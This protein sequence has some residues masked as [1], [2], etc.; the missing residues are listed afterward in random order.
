MRMS[1]LIVVTLTAALVFAPSC[2]KKPGDASY[3]VTNPGSG[4]AN[5]EPLLPLH[6]GSSYLSG[7]MI[8]GFVAGDHPK[9]PMRDGAV[10]DGTA[11]FNGTTAVRYV[12]RHDGA[13]TYLAQNDDGWLELGTTADGPYKHATLLVPKTV[14]VGMTWDSQ[15]DEDHRFKYEV[16]S[17]TE[18]DTPFGTKPVWVIS[19]KGVDTSTLIARSYIEGRGL[20][21]LDFQDKLGGSSLTISQGAVVLSGEFPTPA[22]PHPLAL[23]ELAVSDAMLSELMRKV[24]GD[25]QLSVVQGT[26]GAPLLMAESTWTSQLQDN[27]VS[28]CA[29]V[30]S[31]GLQPGRF[32]AGELGVISDLTTCPTRRFQLEGTNFVDVLNGH[33]DGAM[34]TS[35]GLFWVP[36]EKFGNTVN[37]APNLMSDN[38]VP[39]ALLP[40]SAGG[41]AYVAIHDTGFL[42]HLAVLGNGPELRISDRWAAHSRVY[43]RA[44]TLGPIASTRSMLL[45]TNDGAVRSTF[46]TPSAVGGLALERGFAG[47]WSVGSTPAGTGVFRV[48][49]DGTVDRLVLS[50]AGL[51]LQR[52]GEVQLPA[53]QHLIGVFEVSLEGAPAVIAVTRGLSPESHP[54]GARPYFDLHVF[55]ITTALAAT[56]LQ[57][58]AAF[59]V[60]VTDLRGLYRDVEV[61]WPAGLGPAVLTGW[62]L[63]GKPATAALATPDGNCVIVMRDRGLPQLSIDDPVPLGDEALEGTIPGVGPMAFAGPYNGQRSDPPPSASELWASLTEGGFVAGGAL[64]DETGLDFDAPTPFVDNAGAPRRDAAG[65]GLWLTQVTTPNSTVRDALWLKGAQMKSVEVP[66]AGASSMKPAVTTLGAIPG[67]GVAV[68]LDTPATSSRWIVLPT[69]EAKR[70]SAPADFGPFCGAL[71]D[72]TVCSSGLRQECFGPDGTSVPMALD[73]GVAI[74]CEREPWIPLDDGTF[75]GPATTTSGGA[76]TARI[77]PKTGAVTSYDARQYKASTWAADGTAWAMAFSVPG[78]FDAVPVKVTS[79]GFE[80]LALPEWKLTLRRSAQAETPYLTSVEVGQHVI[81][82]RGTMRYDRND[83]YL[84][85]LPRP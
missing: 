11:T 85:R 81:V 1:R 71:A 17:R 48:L 53:G 31:S 55:K 62:K 5:A 30:S 8:L 19:Q 3:Q 39:L 34:S 69:G 47:I 37:Y 61:C 21:Q 49:Q 43:P 6:E 33:A 20:W 32:S 67:G 4:E 74:D 51:D 28:V 52:A 76:F 7:L 64:L 15:T 65:H 80:A 73:A 84:F 9:F 23:E 14:R 75:V 60:V 78:E 83:A 10:V 58:S 54:V 68:Q 56:P 27:Y 82:V 40:N 41:T 50:E 66:D 35:A 77:D 59:G 38:Q 16:L 13:V 2:A 72:G 46:V 26:S 25:V 42:D 36:R 63:G 22:A 24:G 44:V 29:T 18:Q 45:Q 70:L 12:D 57:R 79:A